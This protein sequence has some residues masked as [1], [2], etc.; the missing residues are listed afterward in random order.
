MSVWCDP[1]EPYRKDYGPQI[2]SAVI[3]VLIIAVFIAFKI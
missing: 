2:M 3:V 1:S